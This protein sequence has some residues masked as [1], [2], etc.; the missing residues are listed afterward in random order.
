MAGTNKP[1][2]SGFKIF[3]EKLLCSAKE[4]CTVQKK[5]ACTVRNVE[6]HFNF[7]M[8]QRKD[9]YIPVLPADTVQKYPVH[10]I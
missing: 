1:V 2:P 4:S 5:K 6:I 7:Q 8:F 10:N 3:S 9:R